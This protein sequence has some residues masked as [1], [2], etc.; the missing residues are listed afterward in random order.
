MAKLKTKKGV[1]KR[2]KITKKG[3]VHY[4]PGGKSHL[5]SSKKQKRLRRLRRQAVLNNKKE[6]KYL[7]RMLPYG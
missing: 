7:K 1:A 6:T 5:L 4:T 2:F 3:K